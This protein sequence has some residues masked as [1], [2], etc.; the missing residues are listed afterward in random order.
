[1]QPMTV[2]HAPQFNMAGAIVTPALFKEMERI[3]SISAQQAASIAYTNAVR[4]T[5]IREAQRRPLKN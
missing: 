5:P 2:V 4:D 1:M 3:S